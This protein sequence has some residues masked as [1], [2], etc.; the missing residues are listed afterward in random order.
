MSEHAIKEI[1]P[2]D[3]GEHIHCVM[4]EAYTVEARLLNAEDFHPLMRCVQD[5][6]GSMNRF[7]GAFEFDELIG[8]CELERMPCGGTLIASTVV[9]PACFR[10]GVASALLSHVLRTDTASA[11]FVST[12]EDNKPAVRLYQKH[13]FVMHDQSVLPDGMRLV[14]LRLV[15]QP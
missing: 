12:A 10:R 5:I 9:T 3:Y 1:S 13:G 14:T 2:F 11:V 7:F 6:S 15:R 8:V 4:Q